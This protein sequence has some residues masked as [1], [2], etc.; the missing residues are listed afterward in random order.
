MNSISTI[1]FLTPI[2]GLWS[3][4]FGGFFDGKRKNFG[5]MD[6]IDRGQEPPER[7]FRVKTTSLLISTFASK[8]VTLDAMNTDPKLLDDD[9]T[10]L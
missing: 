1:Q 4:Y 7:N 6:G 3:G 5:V 8:V 9:L 10:V 2:T